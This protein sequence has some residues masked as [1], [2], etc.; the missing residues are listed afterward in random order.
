MLSPL[1][2]VDLDAAIRLRW[3]LRDIR[4]K[5]TKLTPVSPSDLKTLIEMGLVDLRDDAPMLTNKG[6]QAV[7]E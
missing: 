6:H 1:V 3:A 7:D 2:G 5:R 4:A